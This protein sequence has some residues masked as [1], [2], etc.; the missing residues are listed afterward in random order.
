MSQENVATV[1]SMCEA[2]LSGEFERALSLLDADVI[3]RGTIGGL[4][5]ARV[6]R[7][8]DAVVAS[9]AEGAE[10]WE[11]HSLRTERFVDAGDRIVVFWHEEGRGRSS[12]AEVHTDTA[13]IYTV[14]N[15]RVV[16]VQG[17]MNREH[18]LQAAGLEQ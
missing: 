12:G 3:W 7:G 13:V 5:E 9:F 6:V 10:A 15:D 14:R 18:A 8:R 16:D 2:F 1:R 17:Y 4:D 11:T